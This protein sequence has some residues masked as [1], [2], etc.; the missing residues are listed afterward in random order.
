MKPFIPNDKFNIVD[1][2]VCWKYVL[3]SLD[4]VDEP[5]FCELASKTFLLFYQYHLSDTVPK[6]LLRLLPIMSRYATEEICDPYSVED[7]TRT[8]TKELV[9]QL[10]EGFK[11]IK[12]PITGR[13]ETCGKWMAV[14][15]RNE[16]YQI[17]TVSFDLS[18]IKEKRAIKL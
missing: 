16:H 3:D 15:Y 12:N 6:E 7:I 14:S 1:L 4:G 10:T 17:D 18:P 8:V 5:Y 11:K 2:E 13:L 9:A